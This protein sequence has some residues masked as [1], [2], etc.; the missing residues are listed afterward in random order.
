MRNAPYCVESTSLMVGPL[1]PDGGTH[2]ICFYDRQ[3]A[4][5]VAA[6]SMTIPFGDEIRVV[7]RFSQEVIFRKTAVDGSSGN[8]D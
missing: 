2:S 4:I 6:K 5:V 1:V 3:I 8:G 7:H